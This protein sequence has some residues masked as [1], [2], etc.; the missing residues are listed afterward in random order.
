MN[1]SLKKKFLLFCLVILWASPL[2]AASSWTEKPTYY[3]KMRAKLAF[4][5]ENA[6]FGWMEI[7]TEPQDWHREGKCVAGGVGKRFVNFLGQTAG[8]V[9]HAATSPVTSLDIP[10][11]DGGWEFN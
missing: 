11:P 2:F 4:G 9:V 7:F 10:L 6:A 8:G 3:Q 5:V 1:P